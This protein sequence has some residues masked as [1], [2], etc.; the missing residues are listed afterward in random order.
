MSLSSRPKKIKPKVAVRELKLV[1]TV[2]RRGVDAI[3]TEEDKTLH[4]S[5]QKAQSTTPA[6]HSSSPTKCF[7]FEANDGESNLFCLEG[8]GM[9]NKRQTMVFILSK[10]VLNCILWL[11]GPKQLLGA[12]LNP[13]KIVFRPP[14]QPR[15]SP[16]QCCLQFL[17]PG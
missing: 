15:T 16:N 10:I 4:R 9:L 7:K 3:K 5:S 1:Q 11:K 2:S 17:W 6:N 8:Y 14:S 13:R 12:V